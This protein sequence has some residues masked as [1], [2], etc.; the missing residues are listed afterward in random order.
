LT[1]LY[2]KNHGVRFFFESPHHPPDAAYFIST[3]LKQLD[4]YQTMFASD[5][6]ETSY[7]LEGQGFDHFV[8]STIGWEAHLRSIVLNH[9]IF[10]AVWLNNPW[11]E[12]VTGKTLN[13]PSLFNYDM[14]RF[15]NFTFQKL[16]SLPPGPRFLALHNCFLHSPIHLTWKELRT[17]PDYWN[18]TP[19]GFSYWDWP[20]P[21]D[22]P[23]PTPE[24]WV[25]P[26]YVRRPFLTAFL[27]ALLE[28]MNAQKYLETGT[29][30]FL[31][32]HGERF[33]HGH[34]IYGGI[35][36]IDIKTRE[37]N[38]VLLAI[39]DPKIRGFQKVNSFVSLIDLA[40]TLLQLVGA[41]ENGLSYD[42][43]ALLDAAGRDQ[44]IPSRS[45]WTESMGFVQLNGKDAS[46]PRIAVQTLEESL[47]YQEN[48]RVQVGLD[49]Y[50][51]IMK[52][53][54]TA[55]LSKRFAGPTTARVE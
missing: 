52:N 45:I 13:S 46:F 7:F 42:G 26:Y 1:G 29:V 6:P 18:L 41:P 21:G 33:A 8:S 16:S 10:P 27:Q 4:R 3:R 32:D 24:G 54:E 34:E 2:P 44:E 39:F 11:T 37:Q 15:F 12:A 9:F 47:I 23:I 25:N 50:E 5:Q 43:I 22:P 28:E 36:G 19:K 30:V 55:D 31:S 14:A 40:P 53:K 35:H 20:K 49:Y 17:V 38:N 51:W 48:G